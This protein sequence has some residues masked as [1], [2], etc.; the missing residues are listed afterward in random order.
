MLSVSIVIC[1]PDLKFFEKMLMSL[2]KYTPE[3]SQVIV[4]DNGSDEETSMEAESL[5]IKYIVANKEYHKLNKNIGYGKAHNLALTYATEKYFAVLNDDIEFYEV[6]STPMIKELKDETVGQVGMR[7]GVCNALNQDGGYWSPNSDPEY[8]EGSC[9]MMR[10]ELAKQCGLF[11]EVY[12]KCYWEDSD[13]SLRL[14]QAGY[15]LKDVQ[16]SW[17]HFRMKTINKLKID[18]RGYHIKNEFLFKQRWNSYL[19]RKTFGK[20]VVLKRTMAIGDVFLLSSVIERMRKQRPNDALILMTQ[21]PQ[22]MVKNIDI[23]GII[24]V[25]MPFVCDELIDFD[26]AYE[27]NFTKHMIDAYAEVVGLDPKTVRKTG[28]LYADQTDLEMVKQL[29]PKNFGKFVVL[30]LSKSWVAKQW[31]IENYEKLAGLIHKAGWKVVGLGKNEITGHVPCD[32]NFVNTLDIMKTSLV[33]SISNMFIG[34]EGALAHVAQSL[35]VPSVVLFTCHKPEFT[36]D[37]SLKTL[38]PVVSP[39]AC[40]GCRHFGGG[41]TVFCKRN[42]ECPKA[43]TVEA[44]Y[45]KFL[46][47]KKLYKE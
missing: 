13:L 40:Q 5:L 15:K 10:T 36:A 33:L 47:A 35:N 3:L 7:F 28:I 21:N 17:Q 32:L 4:I 23:D 27:K 38:F 11:D 43:I 12:E 16:V 14:R 30:E 2:V 24:Q 45:E 44:V 8:C 26:Y 29:I 37:L 22:L 34:H 20:T 18:M 39:V 41:Y 1:D 46:E 31:D 19:W 9:F 42:Y 6:W 25:G